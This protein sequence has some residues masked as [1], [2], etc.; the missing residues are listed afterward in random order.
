[1][2]LQHSDCLDC[3][4]YYIAEIAAFHFVYPAD[5]YFIYHIG[6]E[7]QNLQDLCH[8]LQFLQLKTLNRWIHKN[9]GSGLSHT[10]F[11]CCWSDN[12]IHTMIRASIRWLYALWIWSLVNLDAHGNL[13]K[14]NF[15]LCEWCLE[16]HNSSNVFTAL[17]SPR[18]IH[19]R[20]NRSAVSYMQS[21]NSDILNLFNEACSVLWAALNACSFVPTLLA[22]SE[23][24]KAW[25]YEATVVH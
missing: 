21:S 18:M 25:I 10:F 2:I 24:V 11:F 16:Y 6:D 20:R 23:P 17:F 5:A 7:M 13:S 8:H 12:T 19:S 15:N 22:V 9:K 1:M 14:S 4:G 3:L